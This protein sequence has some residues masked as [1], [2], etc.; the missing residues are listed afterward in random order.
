MKKKTRFGSGLWTI[1][2][3]EISKEEKKKTLEKNRKVIARQK[4]IKD[5]FKQMQ[6]NTQQVV[7]KLSPQV[8]RRYVNPD[9]SFKLTQEMV[10]IDCCN[11]SCKVY[12]IKCIQI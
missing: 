10:Q 9:G 4:M 7:Y 5:R 12:V 6:G 8:L 1:N 2:K 3:Q 11:P